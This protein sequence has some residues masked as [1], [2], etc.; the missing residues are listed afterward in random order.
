LAIRK[1]FIN[2]QV[3]M[4]N[5]ECLWGQKKSRNGFK[6]SN[7]IDPYLIVRIQKL[8]PLVY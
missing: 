8:Q 7:C 6:V 4:A 1:E 3:S 2:E 5:L